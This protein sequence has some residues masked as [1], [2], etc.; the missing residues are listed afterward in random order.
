MD[1]HHGGHGRNF[2]CSAES[3]LIGKKNVNV[4]T[5]ILDARY[6]PASPKEVVQEQRHLTTAQD[7]DIRQLVA[8]YPNNFPNQLILYPHRKIHLEL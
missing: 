1:E 6:E 8:L 3:V 5:T 7:N 4:T 2:G